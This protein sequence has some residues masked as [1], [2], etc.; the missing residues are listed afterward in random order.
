M[1]RTRRAGEPLEVRMERILL[2]RALEYERQGQ[3]HKA[4][5]AYE[6]ALAVVMAKKKTLETSLRSDAEKHYRRGLELRKQGKYS[7]AKHE[8]LVAL[9]LWPDFPEVVDHLRPSQIPAGTHYVVHEVKEGEFL[10]AIAEKYYNDQSKFLV[11]ARYNNLRDPGKLYAGMKLK[12]P[13]IENSSFQLPQTLEEA[14][15]KPPKA[16]TDVTQEEIVEKPTKEAMPP[17]AEGRPTSG[18]QKGAV[19]SAA[20][21]YDELA[22]LET[23]YD[24]ASIYEE[25]AVSLLEEGQYLAALHEFHKVYNTDP[26]RK[27]I[28]ESMSWAHYQQGEVHLRQAEYLKARRHFKEALTFN[29]QCT[30]CEASLKKTEDAYKEV[31]YLKGIKHFEEERLEEAMAEWELVSEMDSD[32]KQV[33]NYL[34]R[35]QTLLEKVQELKEKPE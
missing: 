5:Q 27:G 8:F 19:L 2:E 16:N 13:E 15:L 34:S 12:I 11:I 18:D 25:Q 9:H 20:L 29:E 3:P 24:Q 10:T 14:Q 32:Y 22:E 17:V 7:K 35:A 4:L 1:N 28:R 26:S 6:A 33:Q 23:D 21:E 30:S 31:H